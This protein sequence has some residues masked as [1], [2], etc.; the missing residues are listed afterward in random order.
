MRRDNSRIAPGQERAGGG[1]RTP[2]R[3]I[4]CEGCGGVFVPRRASQ[5]YCGPACRP[6]AQRRRAANRLRELLERVLPDDPGR[7]E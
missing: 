5:R 6:L 3:G 2:A 7:A 1:V 4:P